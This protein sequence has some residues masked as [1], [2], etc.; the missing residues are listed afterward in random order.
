MYGIEKRGKRKEKRNSEWQVWLDS[1][2]GGI[3][4]MACME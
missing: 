3:A 4:C 1:R 2:Y